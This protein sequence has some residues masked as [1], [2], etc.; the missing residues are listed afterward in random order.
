MKCLQQ[1][2]FS[3][4]NLAFLG[5]F[6]VGLFWSLPPVAVSALPWTPSKPGR[7]RRGG[8][9]GEESGG[10]KGRD[11]EEEEEGGEE[12]RGGEERG[13][14][15]GANQLLQFSCPYRMRP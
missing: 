1:T 2:T 4:S 11:M 12:G 14:E 7:G 10:E 9:R 8:G 3:R 6:H 5:W 15:K 13:G